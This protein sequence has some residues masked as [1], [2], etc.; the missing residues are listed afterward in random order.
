MR[1]TPILR[2]LATLPP[3]IRLKDATFYRTTPTS[4]DAK[5]LF[6]ETTLEL[7]SDA[8]SA[9]SWAIVG[10]TSR[11]RTDFLNIL[12]G[13]LIPN[14]PTARTYPYLA[15]EEIARKD[16]RLRQP[17]YAIQYVGFDAD[18]GQTN[19][20]GSYLSQRYE[21][22]REIE[23]YTVREY[24][25]GT[26][27]LNSDKSLMNIPAEDALEKVVVDLKLRKLLDMP[28]NHLSNGQT[29]RSKIAKALLMRPE[30]LMLDSPFS[31]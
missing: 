29:R 19:L 31:M 21:S 2:R 8:V 24:L 18:R 16:L 20:R 6:P 4:P 15:T 3:V 25:L 9:E 13:Q 17:H 11:V 5:A 26:M 12:R 27:A 14:V 30:V 1:L 23:D 7:P 28:V 22:K 10:A